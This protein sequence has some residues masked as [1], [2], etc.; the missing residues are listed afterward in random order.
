[1][2]PDLRLSGAELVSCVVYVSVNTVSVT[3][4]AES[5]NSTALSIQVHQAAVCALLLQVMPVASA[6]VVHTSLAS[7]YD[8]LLLRVAS[9]EVKPLTRDHFAK[10]NVSFR[11]VK[12]SPSTSP[13]TRALTIPA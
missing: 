10:A 11:K 12:C 2:R 5:W 7:V 3:S 6:V 13:L 1:V 4:R 9:E 8:E